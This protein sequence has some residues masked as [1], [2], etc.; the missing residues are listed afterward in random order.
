MMTPPKGA[1]MRSI[2]R[3]ILIAAA[4]VT[5][6]LVASLP[7]SATYPGT[8][9]EI[10]YGAATEVRA[11]SPD[12]SG[13]H[14]F[15]SL[16]GSIADVSFSSDGTKAA[17]V[18][19]TRPGA[20]IVLLD[21]VNETW[22]VVL[23]AYRAPTQV[24]SSVA[25]SPRGRRVA[26]SDGSYP[27]HLFTIRVDGTGFTKIANGYG[28][29]DWGSNGR[30]VAQK[31]IFHGDGKRLI[32][33]MDPHGGNQTVIATFPPVHE[34]WNFLTVLTPSWA[35]DASAVVFGAQRSGSIPTSGGWEPMGRTC[36]SSR[37][38]SRSPS[39]GRSS[40]PMAP[41]SCSLCWIRRPPTPISG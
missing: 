21:L 1:P 22:S 5:V 33:T 41:R 34:S 32:T 39:T 14:L 19:Y 15:S 38:R 16:K 31:G 28:Y 25:L 3:H 37:I 27:L 23:P 9:G 4:T 18:N 30:I 17:V 24:L 7:A 2:A 36:T 6:M 29:P 10:V 8:N 35:P 40:P 13:D 11:T 12:G 20:R 26:F